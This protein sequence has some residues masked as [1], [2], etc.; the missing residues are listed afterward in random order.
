MARDICFWISALASFSISSFS[1]KR[2]RSLSRFRNFPNKAARSLASASASRF[3]SSSYK[4]DL[5]KLYL[6][7]LAI[8]NNTERLN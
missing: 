7:Y 1:L 6:S 4:F 2:S 8:V 3:V 5:D